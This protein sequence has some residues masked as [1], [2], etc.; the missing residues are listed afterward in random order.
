MKKE[1]PVNLDLTAFHF[2]LPAKVS[3]THRVTG[4]ILFGAVGVLIWLLDQSLSSAQ[5]FADTRELLSGGFPKFV[6]WVILAALAYHTVVGVKHL[7]MDMG[8]GETLEGGLM[9]AKIALGVS[10]V[11]IILAGVWIW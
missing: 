3:I 7:I 5:G 2:P 6:L 1:R 9:G 11:L 4:I 8:I 10:A